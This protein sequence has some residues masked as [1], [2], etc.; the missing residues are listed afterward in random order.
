GAATVDVA[1]RHNGINYYGVGTLNVTLGSGSDLINVQGTSAVT[2]L[3]TAA[4]NDRV[5]VS[6]NANVNTGNL[7]TLRSGETADLGFRVAEAAASLSIDVKDSRGA[8]VR[9]FAL[10]ATAAGEYSQAWDGKDAAGNQVAAGTY[11]YT[12]TGTRTV[13][14]FVMGSGDTPTLAFSLAEA[15][16]AVTIAV[17]DT[18]GALVKTLTLGATA[19][20][21]GSTT[22]NGTNT[23]GA[24]VAAGA[25]N[26]TVT[27]TSVANGTTFAG[28]VA[29]FTALGTTANLSG[30]LAGN[31]VSFSGDDRPELQFELAE[32][33]ASVSVDIRSAAGTVVRTLAL[34]A[35]AAGA[36]AQAWDGKN[37]AGDVMAAG[38][39]SYT[40]TATRTDA[41]T[42][43]GTM[44]MRGTLDRVSGVL[45]IDAGSGTNGL[46][47][48]DAG[49]RVADTVLVTKDQISGLAPVVINY[50]TT[51]LDT[52]G[53][54]GTYAGGVSIW[55]GYGADTVSVTSTRK[56]TGP[57]V[58]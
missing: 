21:A 57:L 40:V 11:S 36:H 23:S 58:G 42:F 13:S 31:V 55:S 3:N 30:F 25:Y 16:T 54:G 56:D 49:S 1:T 26:F 24:L 41:T 43:V 35:T 29:T 47:V 34:G 6:S 28:T 48:S 4:G 38:A 53:N 52:L 32:A 7:V 33:A 15:A 20:G 18:S 10:G 50:S 2:N 9:N 8:V 39:Y 17:T 37:T 14:S 51:G 45:S 19:A 44:A 22:W 46:M 12:V 5:F 27:G